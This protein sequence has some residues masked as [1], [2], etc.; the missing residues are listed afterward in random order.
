M[1]LGV[2]IVPE[3]DRLVVRAT[4]DVVRFNS[5]PFR[6]EYDTDAHNSS[7]SRILEATPELP[8]ARPSSRSSRQ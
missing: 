2:E 7:L 6:N 4:D 8:V 3:G 5:L 1:T